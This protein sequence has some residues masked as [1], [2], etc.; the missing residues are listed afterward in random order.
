[1]IWEVR[2]SPLSP[3]QQTW[4][5][6]NCRKLAP[7]FVSAIS[8]RERI[9]LTDGLSHRCAAVP[10]VLACLVWCKVKSR[11]GVRKMVVKYWGVLSHWP[12]GGGEFNLRQ[13][14]RES[15][16]W[17]DREA[18]V[19]SKS[20]E[21]IWYLLDS[22]EDWAAASRPYRQPSCTSSTQTPDSQTVSVSSHTQQ[23]EIFR[24]KSVRNRSDQQITCRV[25]GRL[26]T[27]L[28]FRL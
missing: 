2:R 6:L 13:A 3:P 21:D 24:N 22:S 25:S 5:S 20:G 23:P 9:V 1:M 18:K 27:Y 14:G 17:W 11:L 7:V 10:T 28:H 8:R 12:G 4:S 26:E 16:Y 15:Y 19:D